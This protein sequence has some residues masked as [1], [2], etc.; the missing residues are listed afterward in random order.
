MYDNDIT[1][2]YVDQ[3]GQG[4]TDNDVEESF[5]EYLD[6]D[7]M[8]RI[9]DPEY[10]P[11]EVLAAVDPVAYRCGLVDYLDAL[12]LVEFDP[13]TFWPDDEDGWVNV[14]AQAVR[15]L[16]V[17]GL[18]D[19]SLTRDELELISLNVSP[20]VG[21]LGDRG[22]ARLGMTDSRKELEFF[23]PQEDRWQTGPTLEM[24]DRF[25]D[26]LNNTESPT[27]GA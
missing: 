20:T 15:F 19:H 1:P 2:D 17:S 9:G 18:G 3:D 7:D 25:K 22:S 6:A 11:S 13:G 16:L 27:L 14:G 23:C 21:W 12:D 10:L 26:A 5:R 24:F 8:V 4:W